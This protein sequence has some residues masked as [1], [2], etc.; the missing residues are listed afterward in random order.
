MIRQALVLDAN[1]LIRAV[2]GRRVRGLLDRFHDSTSFFTPHEAFTD[3]E[4]YLPV[5]F[6]KRGLDWSV[7]AAALAA[8]P[9]LVQAVS[10]EVYGG[11]EIEA[12]AR[13]RDQDDW[14][15]LATA[16]SRLFLI[17]PQMA[18][19]L[20]GAKRR[21]NPDC[22]CMGLLDCRASLV[23]TAISVGN[24]RPAFRGSIRV[25]INDSLLSAGLSCLD[26]GYGFLR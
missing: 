15:V 10:A 6:E 3:A 22:R 26:R 12:R 18:P 1:I 20:R 21:G 4:T 9:S 8:I 24:Q 2:L 19:S 17:G 23:M 7:G 16:L 5:I 14:P 13:I 11:F 25:P